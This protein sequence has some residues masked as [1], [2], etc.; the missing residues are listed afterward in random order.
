ELRAHCGQNCASTTPTS[1]RT[2]TTVA[3]PAPRRFELDIRTTF[4]VLE[5]MKRP[6]SNSDTAVRVRIPAAGLDVVS[7]G[8]I[9]RQELHGG[10]HTPDGRSAACCSLFCDSRCHPLPR[11]LHESWLTPAFSASSGSR[12]AKCSC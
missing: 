12:A 6:A 8:A 5:G 7:R 2:E 11:R 1:S 9:R 10:L 3:S 4:R